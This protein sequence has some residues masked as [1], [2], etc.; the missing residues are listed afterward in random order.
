MIAYMHAQY[1]RSC[2]AQQFLRPAALLL[3]RF[4]CLAITRDHTHRLLWC[5]CSA[6]ACTKL[7]CGLLVPSAGCLGGPAFGSL[8]H[9]GATG[10]RSRALTAGIQRGR[11][12]ASRTARWFPCCT[13]ASWRG[14]SPVDGVRPRLTKRPLP[15]WVAT[16]V[17][18]ATWR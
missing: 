2:L 13:V 10:S 4:V 3:A 7:S 6:L 14:R 8:S 15:N 1:M 5:G 12:R 9:C 17:T 11:T 18:A 16:L